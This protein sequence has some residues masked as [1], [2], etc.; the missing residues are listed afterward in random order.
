MYNKD[1]A[2]EKFLLENPSHSSKN[3]T[4]YVYHPKPKK[5]ITNKKTISLYKWREKNKIKVIAHRKVFS[6]KRNGRLKKKN[7]KICRESN[8]QAHHEDYTK[9]LN[10]IWLCRTHH[11][12]FD[13]RRRKLDKSVIHNSN[14]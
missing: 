13:V 3:N 14:V 8:T 9:P 11:I 10:V 12:E 1:L 7:C 6:S 4:N 2:R 5:I